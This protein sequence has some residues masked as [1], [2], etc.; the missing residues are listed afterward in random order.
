MERGKGNIYETLIPG[1][2][3]APPV[4][5]TPRSCTPIPDK[6]AHHLN[7]SEISRPESSSCSIS[8]AAPSNHDVVK[9][10]WTLHD[11][12]GKKLLGKSFNDN[13]ATIASGDDDLLDIIDALPEAILT[14]GKL[15]QLT[16]TAG[17]LLARETWLNNPIDAQR[18]VSIRNQ[19]FYLAMKYKKQRNDALNIIESNL[20][21][22]LNDPTTDGET[23]GRLLEL[24]ESGQYNNFINALRQ[25]DA[26][27][28]R[29]DESVSRVQ[30]DQT[31]SLGSVFEP[32]HYNRNMEDKDIC[33]SKP[34]LPTASGEDAQREDCR[35]LSEN[36]SRVSFRSGVEREHRALRNLGD[37]DRIQGNDLIVNM[38]TGA[39]SSPHTSGGNGN[40]SK[41][42]LNQELENMLYHDLEDLTTEMNSLHLDIQWSTDEMV[43]VKPSNHTEGILISYEKKTEKIVETKE[44]LNNTYCRYIENYGQS[45]NMDTIR[46]NVKNVS[47]KLTQLRE[48]LWSFDK[49]A[50]T[51]VDF[52]ETSYE[53]QRDARAPELRIDAFE[54]GRSLVSYLNWL[55][56]NSKL[57]R[58]ILDA[59]IRKTL[60]K[61]ALERLILQHPENSRTPE[62]VIIFLL[63][64]YGRTGQIEAQLRAHHEEVGSLNS[65]F[66]GGHKDSI[67]LKMCNEVVI[68]ADLHL[69]G[70]RSILHLRDLCNGYLGTD[71]TSMSFE[72]HLLTHSYTSWVAKCTLTCSQINKLS[73]MKLKSGKERLNSVITE[74]EDLRRVAER[75]LHS[76]MAEAHRDI[77]VAGPILMC[78]QITPAP[79]EDYDDLLN[80]LL[81]TS[82]S[83]DEWLPN[84]RL[85][86]LCPPQ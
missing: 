77:P 36:R 25:V 17:Y 58:N 37:T 41:R 12:N 32:D 15:I 45:N 2:L 44:K 55:N 1:D 6:E 60:P 27:M 11:N 81:L 51:R 38:M 3:Q 5:P 76:G 70:L 21:S 50:R 66:S 84:Q 64:S 62:D 73:K 82:P 30:Q 18:Y 31:E 19:W 53:Q 61:S 65:F 56:K 34:V 67:N 9:E 7:G 68:N 63:K 23:K 57:P 16:N 71:E 86:P 8:S 72:E 29:L 74:V 14:E 10:T 83:N 59:N 69:A 22:L 54:E 49:M 40:G 42:I 4:R 85:G 79:A 24:C 13:L 33:K 47:S 35:A 52:E 20:S 48:A 43:G 39:H 46:S 78:N 26:R 28:V 75:L 80:D